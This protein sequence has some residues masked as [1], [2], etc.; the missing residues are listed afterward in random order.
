MEA[1]PVAQTTES[2]NWSITYY[3]KEYFKEF[4]ILCFNTRFSDKNIKPLASEVHKASP[5]S[6]QPKGGFP[7]PIRSTRSSPIKQS[8]TGLASGRGGRHLSDFLHDYSWLSK[9]VE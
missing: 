7:L 1:V 5:L 8:G 6:T 4:Y 2:K 9:K 3:T